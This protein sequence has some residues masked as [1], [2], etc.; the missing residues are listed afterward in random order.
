MRGPLGGCEML[1]RVC[2]EEENDTM[3]LWWSEGNLTSYMVS[4][5]M[6]QFFLVCLILV[7]ENLNMIAK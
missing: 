1:D 3:W 4:C 2:V 6:Q 7:F 5:Y